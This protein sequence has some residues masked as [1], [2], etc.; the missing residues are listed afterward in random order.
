MISL[1]S[2]IIFTNQI[3]WLSSDYKVQS[4]SKIHLDLQQILIFKIYN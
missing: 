1:I 3:A 2:K 4:L